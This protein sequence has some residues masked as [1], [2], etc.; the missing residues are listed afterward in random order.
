MFCLFTFDKNIVHLPLIRKL[1]A[2]TVVLFILTFSIIFSINSVLG[3]LFC[4][5]H[6][7]VVPSFTC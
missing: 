5:G 6:N 2:S 3:T 4:V 7:S 1:F